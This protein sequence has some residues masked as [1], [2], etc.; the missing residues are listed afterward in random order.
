M[1]AEAVGAERVDLAGADVLGEVHGRELDQG[2]RDG[3]RGQSE[4]DAEVGK[5]DRGGLEDAGALQRVS[6]ESGGVWRPGGY[7]E[8]MT[9][10]AEEGGEEGAE[11]VEG[12]R[13]VEPA[14]RRCAGGPRWAT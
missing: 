10:R 11:G 4:G 3:E 6:G 12:L 7:G 13:E 9:G 5:L 1:V 2:E 8:R 14:G